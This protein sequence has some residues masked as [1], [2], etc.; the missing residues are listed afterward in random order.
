MSLFKRRRT[1]EGA[2]MSFVEH[3]EV[4]RGHILRSVIAIVLGAVLV[5]V[6]NDF[7][8]KQVILGPTHADFPTYSWLCNLG[9][10]IGLG[11]ALCM[12]ELGVKMQS[13][14]VSGQFSM[15]FTV[16]LVGG[17]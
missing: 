15:F 5:G 6:Y 2:E 3:L 1:D 17:L 8:I 12:K 11:D 16:M 7:F 13:T 4:F 10:K 9:N 14:T